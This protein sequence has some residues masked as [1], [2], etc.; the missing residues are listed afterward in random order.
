MINL[1]KRKPKRKIKYTIEVYDKPDLFLN[2]Q[3]YCTPDKRG[4]YKIE[5]GT[6]LPYKEIDVVAHELGHILRTHYQKQDQAVNK[7]Y[8][9]I[10]LLS[11]ADVFGRE[12]GAWDT[13]AEIRGF[14]KS[15]HNALSGYARYFGIALPDLEEIESPSPEIT[16]TTGNTE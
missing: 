11:A 7:W 12:I 9:P 10:A 13:A 15:M 5:I 3:A 14:K 6:G 16:E 2:A 4:V 1:F 8:A